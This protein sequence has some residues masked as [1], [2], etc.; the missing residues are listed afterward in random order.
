MY[1]PNSETFKK[2]INE[3]AAVHVLTSKFGNQESIN[4]MVKQNRNFVQKV[5]D[6]VVEKLNSLINSGNKVRNERLFFEDLKKRI[7]NSLNSEYNITNKEAGTRLATVE[8]NPYG[9]VKDF[10]EMTKKEQEEIHEVVSRLAAKF[11][12][13]EESYS[14]RDINGNKIIFDIFSDGNYRITEIEKTKNIIEEVV[15]ERNP[16]KDSRYSMA[17]SEQQQRYSRNGNESNRNKGTS[18]QDVRI[19]TKEQSESQDRPSNK[20]QER[21][22]RELDN[23]SFS[24]DSDGREL[25]KQQ[26]EYF[27]DSKVRD[28]NGNLLTLYHGSNSEFTVFD[29][30]KAGESNKNAR[31]G[32]WFT[33]SK[34]GAENFAR[35]V[36]YGNKKPTAYEAYLNIKNPKIYETFDNTEQTEKLREEYKKSQ[37][38]EKALYEKHEY[39]S[40]GMSNVMAFLNYKSEENTIKTLVNDFGYTKEQAK[41]YINE[42]KEV[43]EIRK[44]TRK[45]EKEVSNSRYTDSYE[46]F[47]TD[48]YKMAGKDAEDANFGGIGMMLD[49]ER[50][51][52]QDYVDSLKKARI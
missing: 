24:Y 22:N 3:E 44:E 39:D 35:D 21:N 14:V 32:F 1:D 38:K 18:K 41:Q 50:Q 25:T 20:T 10:V 8:N 37:S 42:A 4:Q 34:T 9:H 11:V 52:V 6:W 16:N 33:P 5:Y 19:S 13:I 46:Q 26:Q 2:L 43:Q 45:L 27:K 17:S 36:W 48:I 49:N 47:R 40:I 29:I 12:G 28:E 30:N 7:A 31:V 15:D 23:S 51:I